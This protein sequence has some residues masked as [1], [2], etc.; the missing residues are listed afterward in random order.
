MVVERKKTGGSNFKLNFISGLLT[1]IPLGVTWLL[2]DLVFSQLSKMGNPLL[3]ALYTNIRDDAP[4]LAKLLAP[5][6]RS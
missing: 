2:L 6:R 3:R 5:S 4:G 1:L